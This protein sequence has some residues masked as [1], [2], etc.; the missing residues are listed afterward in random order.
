MC[1]CVRM[2]RGGRKGGWGG[3]VGSLARAPRLLSGEER[4]RPREHAAAA[5][6]RPAFSEQ[7]VGRHREAVAR[8][9]RERGEGALAQPVE[10][11]AE[12]V[13]LLG[14][15]AREVDQGEP[16]GAPTLK[17]RSALPCT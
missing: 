15:E 8:G 12:E 16:G 9:V 2:L 11:L 4:T 17:T 13:D 14:L 1:V 3:W 6:A 5:R 10:L 7:L